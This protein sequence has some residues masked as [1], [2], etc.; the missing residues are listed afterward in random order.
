MPRSA[1]QYVIFMEPIEGGFRCTCPDLPGV[2]AQGLTQEETER[3]MRDAIAKAVA[4]N[5]PSSADK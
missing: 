3:K 2:T 4:A 1:F 5:I